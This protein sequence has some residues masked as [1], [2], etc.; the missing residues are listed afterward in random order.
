MNERVVPSDFRKLLGQVVHFGQDRVT[1]G[2]KALSVR[3]RRYGAVAAV[4]QRHPQFLLQRLDRR[5]DGGLGDMQF[6]G[7]FADVSRMAGGGKITHLG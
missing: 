6:I 2:K 1:A 4:Q 3:G 5:G 7:R